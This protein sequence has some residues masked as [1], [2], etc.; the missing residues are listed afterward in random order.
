VALASRPRMYRV[1][2]QALALR[3]RNEKS[4]QSTGKEGE[5]PESAR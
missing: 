5:S 2:E 1:S 3:I 4:A